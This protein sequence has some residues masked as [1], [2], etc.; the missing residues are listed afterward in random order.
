MEACHSSLD[1]Q[2]YW[3]PYSPYSSEQEVLSLDCD[4]FCV[5]LRLGTEYWG[6][7]TCNWYLSIGNGGTCLPPEVGGSGGEGVGFRAIGGYALPAPAS[8]LTFTGLSNAANEDIIAVVACTGDLTGGSYPTATYGGLPMTRD[9]RVL[10]GGTTEGTLTIFRFPTAIA[11]SGTA[12][13]A[14][15][16]GASVQDAIAL[17]GACEDTAGTLD[18]TPDSDSGASGDPDSGSV[19][20]TAGEAVVIAAHLQTYP[21][22]PVLP[23]TPD[24]DFAV[25]AGGQMEDGGGNYLTLT[26]SAKV[27]AAAA[28]SCSLSGGDANDGWAGAIIGVE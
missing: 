12:T 1:S 16:F 14:V 17:V 20:T 2:F 3:G 26:A 18:G 24:N 4:P 27:A 19:T 10:A 25:W 7:S 15:D 5:V 23:G 6:N 11:A 22:E 28:H 9:V 21:S 8:T 13:L